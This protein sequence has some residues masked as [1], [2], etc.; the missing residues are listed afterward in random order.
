M[1]TFVLFDLDNTLV[2]SLHLKALRD[3]RR[4]PAVYTQ[5]KTVKLFDGVAQAWTELRSLSVYLGV[6]THSP[7]PYAERMLD[8]VGLKPDRLIAY[9]DLNGKKKP[10]PY[11]YERCCDRRAATTG[12]AVGDERPDLVAADAFGCHGI[13]AGWSRNASHTA[14]DCERA[15][16]TF[17]AHPAEIVQISRR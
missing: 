6:V 8:H 9:H 7:R 16:W 3:A 4:W 13:F 1:M 14:W 11:G 10:S 17:A 2:D 12:A 15:G 5:I